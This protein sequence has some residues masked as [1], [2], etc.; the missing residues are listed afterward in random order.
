MHFFSVLMTSR[1]PNH[2]A[3]PAVVLHNVPGYSPDKK[4][5]WNQI[6]EGSIY[7]R[8]NRFTDA[9]NWVPHT[10]TA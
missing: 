10:Q 3:L 4:K 8:R 5:A 6:A 2:A 9:R 1:S 7:F